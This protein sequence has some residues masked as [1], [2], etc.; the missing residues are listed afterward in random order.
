MIIAL[1]CDVFLIG[2]LAFASVEGTLPNIRRLQYITVYAYSWVSEWPLLFILLKIGIKVLASF[3]GVF[4]TWLSQ[5]FF[6]FD[7]LTMIGLVVIFLDGYEARV[8]IHEAIKDYSDEVEFPTLSRDLSIFSDTFWNRL[9]NPFYIP[10]DVIQYANIA[11]CTDNELAE[12]QT[13]QMQSLS[14]DIYTRRDTLAT[15]K[16]VFLFIHGGGWVRGDKASPYPLIRH[17]AESGLTVV[18]INY[19]LAS[20]AP[21]PAQLIDAK[22]ALRW[23]KKTIKNFGG[24]PN[25]IVVGGDGAGGH[26]AALVA[27]TPNNA[28]Y[29]PGFELVDTS[30]QAAVLINAITDVLNETMVWH[31]NFAEH[32]AKKIAKLE[33][34]NEDFLRQHSPIHNIKPDSVPFLV[35]HGDRDNLVPF[36]LSNNFMERFKKVSKSEIQFVQIP[37]GHHIYHQFTSPRSQY[38]SIGIEKWIKHLYHDGKHE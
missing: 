23:V 30:V 36:Q 3:F 28:D 17:L 2:G 31:S 16:P 35:F 25:F 10:K 27:L 38:Q 26:L 12:V 19:R 14:L 29:Q 8:A 24:D 33:T 6:V 11:Y 37:G 18:A 5:A 13:D 1:L 4:R 7:I 34:N 15:L 32:F 9:V 20:V 22:R 21:Y